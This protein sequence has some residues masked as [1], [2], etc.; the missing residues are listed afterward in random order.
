[1]SE[2]GRRKWGFICEGVRVCGCHEWWWLIYL[3]EVLLLRLL[4]LLLLLPLPSLLRYRSLPNLDLT[5]DHWQ[6]Y[7]RN[8]AETWQ[9][10]GRNIAETWQKYDSNM[11]DRRQKMAE[12]MG[13]I[14]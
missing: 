5:E 12:T 7:G 14:S 4:L 3:V 13:I 8:I 9:K 11:V 2:E 6:K 10:Y 1:M